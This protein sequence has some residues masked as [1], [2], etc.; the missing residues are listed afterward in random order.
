[1]ETQQEPRKK[2]VNAAVT[3][4]EKEAVEMA[5][6]VDELGSVSEALRRFTVTQLIERGEEILSHL[7]TVARAS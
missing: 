1:M 7:R 5:V 4:T 2:V 6:K 3:E